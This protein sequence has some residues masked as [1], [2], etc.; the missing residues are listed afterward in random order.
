PAAL[1]VDFDG[2]GSTDDQN[3]IVSYLWEFGDG[4]PTLDGALVNH[5]YTSAGVY[6]AVLTVTDAQGLSGSA[7]ISITVTAPVNNNP[8]AVA[9]FTNGDSALQYNIDGS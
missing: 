9:T 1:S 2:S 6:N 8:I 3:A 4:S 5:V 7:A